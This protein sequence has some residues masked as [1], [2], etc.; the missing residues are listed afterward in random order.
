MSSSGVQQTMARRATVFSHDSFHYV[1]GVIASIGAGSLLL[2]AVAVVARFANHSTAGDEV[3]PGVV[4]L[5]CAASL[6]VAGVA[7]VVYVLRAL[8]AQAVTLDSRAKYLQSE[9]DEVI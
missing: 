9:L 6:V 3:A 5:I 4:G 8:L 2:F 1:D 7:L